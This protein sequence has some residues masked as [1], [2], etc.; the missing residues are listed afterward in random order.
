MFST[1][2]INVISSDEGFWVEVLGHTKVRY[3]EDDVEIHFFMEFTTG[4]S[5]LVIFSRQNKIVGPPNSPRIGQALD[6]V[7]RERVI[8][9]IRSAFRFTGWEIDVL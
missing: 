2:A 8:E 9:R 4:N 6:D 7:E 3:V 5:G 1:P